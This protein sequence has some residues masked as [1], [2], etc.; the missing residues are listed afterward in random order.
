M[1]NKDR[2]RISRLR[3]VLT[4]V[5]FANL[6]ASGS[7]ATA[8]GLVTFDRDMRALRPAIEAVLYGMLCEG[9][10]EK[11]GWEIGWDYYDPDRVLDKIEEWLERRI[12]S[13]WSEKGTPY[14][15]DFRGASSCL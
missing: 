15:I 6:G 9:Y 1:N 10:D 8:L 3:S 14:E 2:E 13:G 5:P 11:F 4:S 12:A 7:T